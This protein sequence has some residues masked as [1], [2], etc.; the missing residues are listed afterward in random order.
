LPTRTSEQ[1]E[2][3]QQLGV[4]TVQVLLAECLVFPFGLATSAYLGRTL[5]PQQFGLLAVALAVGDLVEWTLTSL[6]AR[7]TVQVIGESPDWRPVAASALRLQT[8]IGA[9]AAVAF[10]L[11]AGPLAAAMG[12]PS[13]ATVLRLIALEFPILAAGVA[14]RNVLTGRGQFRERAF[15]SALRWFA[16]MV[17]VILLVNSGLA[18]GGA[19]AGEILSAIVWL[20]LAFAL[21]A[22]PVS[23]EIPPG[24]VRR[25]WQLARP[26]FILTLS[27]RVLDKA[28]VVALKLLGASA[29]E[30][31]WYAAAQNFGIAPG[32]FAVSFSP[33]LLSA[34]ATTMRDHGLDAG[35][36]LVRNGLRV[37]LGTMPFVAFGAGAAPEVVR[38]IY[39][40]GYEP[41][42]R[43]AIPL[44][45]G[46]MG[47]VL[48][49]VASSMLA[50]AD[51]ATRISRLVWPVTAIAVVLLGLVVPSYGAMGAAIVIGASSVAGAVIVVEVVRRC[52]EVALPTGTLVRARAISA[53]TLAAGLAWPAYGAWLIV[54]T[55]VFVT[56]IVAAFA[57]LGE[58]DYEVVV[59]AKKMIR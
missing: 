37:T 25:L 38:L 59:L 31:G 36:P 5:G 4:G 29:P 46:A 8:A 14:C 21:A 2:R 22:V 42:A 34:L 57:V 50:A 7:A 12:E 32:L 6:F 48:V 27:L 58:F 10:L 28:G 17:L 19:V 35:R 26:M 18:L 41:A 16:R 54:K 51:Q 11:I 55:M 43:L 33:L 3:R 40:P 49:S 52:W 1:P 13:L 44:L 20:G 30:A 45:A 39:G 15:S 56:A 23:A 24:A 53:A 9:I 47:A